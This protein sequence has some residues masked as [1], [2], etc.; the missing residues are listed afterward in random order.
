MEEKPK[1]TN[2][3]VQIERDEELVKVRLLAANSYF[4]MCQLYYRFTQTKG[5]LPLKFQSE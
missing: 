2:P 3:E 5:F 4:I 1:E